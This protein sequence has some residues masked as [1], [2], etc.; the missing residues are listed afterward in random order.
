MPLGQRGKTPVISCKKNWVRARKLPVSRD[1]HFWLWLQIGFH[2]DNE[3]GRILRCAAR[4]RME[5][6]A[7]IKAYVVLHT[8]DIFAYTD[9]CMKRGPREEQGRLPQRSPI[10]ANPIHGI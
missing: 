9:V 2:G 4:K 3:R 1:F 6:V 5:A 8:R 7:I 10:R